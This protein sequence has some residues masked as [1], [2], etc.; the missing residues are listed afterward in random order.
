MIPALITGYRRPRESLTFTHKCASDNHAWLLMSAQREMGRR[1]AASISVLRDAPCGRA[2]GTPPPSCHSEAPAYIA[3]PIRI[4][5]FMNYY[6]R[7]NRGWQTT[8]GWF[9]GFPAV[10]LPTLRLFAGV[11]PKCMIICAFPMREKPRKI[12]TLSFP[13]RQGTG[14]AA[15]TPTKAGADTGTACRMQTYG[16]RSARKCGSRACPWLEQ[17]EQGATAEGFPPLDARFRGNDEEDR[18]L[19]EMA[20]F[21]F[22]QGLRSMRRGAGRTGAKPVRAMPHP[23]AQCRRGSDR[24]RFRSCRKTAG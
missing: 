12:F 19:F 15:L 11:I 1:E 22:G 3:E 4:C 23:P 7:N 8:I 5:Q 13:V 20:T 2:S 21:I 16:Q 18:Q 24:T 9:S 17:H 10:S 14:E 6:I